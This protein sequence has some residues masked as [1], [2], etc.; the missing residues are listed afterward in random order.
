MTPPEP[1][2]P[3]PTVT[4][5]RPPRPLVAIPLPTEIAPLLPELVVPDVNDKR[6]LVPDV[7]A[8]TVFT[9]IAPDVVSTPCPVDTVM[10]PPV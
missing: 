9:T 6:P 3:L 2:L 5:M 10:A 4:V 7:P 1:L 8:S